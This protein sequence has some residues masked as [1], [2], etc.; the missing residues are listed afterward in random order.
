MEPVESSEEQTGSMIKATGRSRISW[1]ARFLPAAAASWATNN[2]GDTVRACCCRIMG[3]KHPGRRGSSLLLPHHGQD[4][5]K[6]GLRIHIAEKHFVV[7]GK[8]RV[9]H[10]DPG[11][12]PGQQLVD[13][14][15]F[16][17]DH[18]LHGC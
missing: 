9:H 13:G 4:P 1:D 15:I 12:Y 14:V 7:K 18:L 17:I 6:I 10:Q 5:C 8:G 3:N 11:P 16:F 2:P